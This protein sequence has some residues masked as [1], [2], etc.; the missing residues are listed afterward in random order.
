M[1]K[2]QKKQKETEG[3]EASC[4]KNIVFLTMTDKKKKKKKKKKKNKWYLSH[5][6]TLSCCRDIK[7]QVFW[8]T[9]LISQGQVT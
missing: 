5:F 1:L 6:C 4:V 7:D 9:T 8:V 2:M 3:V